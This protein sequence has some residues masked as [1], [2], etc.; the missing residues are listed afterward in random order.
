MFTRIIPLVAVVRRAIRMGSPT[1]ASVEATGPK[2]E[3]REPVLMGWG[4]YDAYG[5][6]PASKS[7]EHRPCG[8]MV[9][10]V[11]DMPECENVIDRGLAWRCGEQ[12]SLGASQ[13]EG[14]GCGAYVCGTHEQ[15]HGC[16]NPYVWRKVR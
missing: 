4:R 7:Y 8:Y 12:A 13:D 11:C 16:P 6:N 10:A 1:T 9:P 14:R 15:D 2:L 5:Y 3:G